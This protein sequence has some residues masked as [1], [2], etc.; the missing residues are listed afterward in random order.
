MLEIGPEVHKATG[1]SRKKLCQI[2]MSQ[3]K[4]GLVRRKR[5]LEEKF[6]PT[7]RQMLHTYGLGAG[8][9]LIMT[10]VVRITE[11]LLA[12]GRTAGAR[13]DRAFR[14][15]QPGTSADRRPGL[16]AT[17]RPFRCWSWAL[18]RLIR[19]MPAAAGPRGRCGLTICNAAGCTRMLTADTTFS[20]WAIDT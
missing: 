17:P 7:W 5:R 4:G 2:R 20:S 1:K 11:I 18:R 16:F 9:R 14:H 19:V 15:D 13:K 12:S 3:L 6:F 8:V 10:G